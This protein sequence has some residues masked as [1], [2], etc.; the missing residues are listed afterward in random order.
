MMQPPSYLLGIDIGTGSARAGLF[1]PHGTML[2]TATE[3]IRMWNPQPDHYEQSSENIWHAIAVTIGRVLRE[4]NIPK[5]QVAGISF[6]ATCSLVV[7][8]KA[9]NP[10]AVNAEGDAER[11]IIVWMDH[12]AIAE[13][14]EIN[15]GKYDVLQYVGGV[16]SPEMETPKLKWLKTHLPHTW[17]NAGK[18]LDLADYLTYRASGVDARSYCTVVCKW[19]YLGHEGESGKWDRNYLQSIGIE[20]AFDGQKIANDIRPMGAN[21]GKLTPQAAQELGL[22]TNCAVGVGIIDAHAGGLGVLGSVWEGDTKIDLAKLETALALIGGTSNCHMAVS[23]NAVFVPGIWGPYFGAMVPGLWLLEGGQTSAGS[24]IDHVIQDHA[25][26]PELFAE[27]EQKN[28]TPYELLNAEIERLAQQANVPYSA[29]L[30]RDIHVLGDFLGNR[31][32]HAD[33]LAKGIVEGVTLDKSRTSLALRYY[34]AVQAVA[35]GSRDIVHAMN[36]KGMQIDSLYV[37][38]GGTKNPLWLQEHA[39]ATGLTLILPQ[40]SE[41]TACGIYPNVHAAM[42]GMSKRGKVIKPNPQTAGYHDAK[43]ACYQDLYRQQVERRK[44]MRAIDSL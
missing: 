33:P 3:P 2:A 39:D 4:A 29:L 13:A 16:I 34:A 30:T 20:D 35:Y 41:A 40:E 19:M 38:G 1:D 32:P 10:L 17:Q 24:T 37:T 27:A 36:E 11:N 42:Q 44:T 14:E 31:C 7:L 18:F 12:R 22:T 25:A 21:L 6:D 8:D 28:V 26:A 15:A 23:R 5:E 9:S 43:F